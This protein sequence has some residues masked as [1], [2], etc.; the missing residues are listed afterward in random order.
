MAKINR[1]NFVEKISDM[2]KG[3]VKEVGEWADSEF[4]LITEKEYEELL[5]NVIADSTKEL[6]EALRKYSRKFTLKWSNSNF[7]RIGTY[8][9]FVYFK[10]ID[11]EAEAVELDESMVSNFVEFNNCGQFDIT[12]NE[13]TYEVKF[14][15]GTKAIQTDCPYK[16]QIQNWWFN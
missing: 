10:F 13:K 14:D 9:T 15:N 8:G 12:I 7:G 16:D 2:T 4:I 1:K 11:E 5:Q 3:Y 6:S